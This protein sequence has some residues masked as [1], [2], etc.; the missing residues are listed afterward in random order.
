[1]IKQ[2]TSKLFSFF[3]NKDAFSQCTVIFTFG[4][5][6]HLLVVME[7]VPTTSWPL[8]SSAS[9][10]FDLRHDPKHLKEE[11]TEVLKKRSAVKFE[12]I[13]N[14]F[15]KNYLK[16]KRPKK[17]DTDF[18]TVTFQEFYLNLLLGWLWRLTA[19]QLKFAY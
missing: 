10:F 9:A 2:K 4:I 7:T 14:F 15:G 8:L 5:H 13:F 1:M 18:L 16:R 12:S 6:L 11:E 3:G 19:C 17:H